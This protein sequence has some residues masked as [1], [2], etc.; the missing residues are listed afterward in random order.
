LFES[1]RNGTSGIFKQ[2]I[3]A[4]DAQAVIIGQQRPH[5]PRISAG[6][7]WILYAE[8]AN[9]L[10]R[11]P[12]AG[13]SQQFVLEMR[14]GADFTCSRSSAG[15]CVLS[16]N[17]QDGKQ[18]TLTAF[19]PVRGRGKV[20]RTIPK[21]AAASFVGEISPDGTVFA[22]AKSFEPEIH[23]RLLSLVGNTDREITVK[24]WPGI[25][26]LNWSADGKGLFCGS[27]SP[28]AD[29]VMYVDLEGNARVLWQNIGGFATWGLPSPDGRYLAIRSD[30]RNSNVW[31]LEGF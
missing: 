16:E 1:D 9:R 7:E 2:Q 31:M 12:I 27:F 19:D 22:M 21:D 25:T 24:G 28:R 30:V 14:D 13:G 29:T 10:M 11:V 4:T 6:G 26:G 15:Q 5:H 23:I 3:N 20:L 18:L 8:G 17:S